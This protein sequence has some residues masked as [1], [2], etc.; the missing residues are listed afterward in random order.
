[1]IIKTISVDLLFLSRLGT[2]IIGAWSVEWWW[3]V[4]L[5]RKVAGSTLPLA[6]TWG[7]W[8]SPSLVIAC[9]T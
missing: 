5:V 8:A 1:M 6:A 9:M 3:S 7:P 4:P 2:G